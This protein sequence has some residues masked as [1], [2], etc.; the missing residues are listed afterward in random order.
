MLFAVLA[1]GPSMNQ[2]SADYVRGK[3]KVIAV[4]DAYKLAPWAD[5]LVSHDSAWWKHHPEALNFAGEKYS[6]NLV[7]G[8]TQRKPLGA[9]ASCN[10]GLMGMLIAKEMGATKILLLGFDMHGEHYF[11]KH[12]EPLKNTTQ[13]RFEDLRKQFNIWV[14][15]EVIN[16]TPG[17]ALK[18][19]PIME[20]KDAI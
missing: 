18:H 1:T 19:F 15:P 6:Y 2:E 5:V 13:R 4:S 16:C 3:C 14:R 9:P 20:L 8:V 10:S 7:G 17:S 11:G 12:P